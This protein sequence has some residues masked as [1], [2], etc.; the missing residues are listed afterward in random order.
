MTDSN[1][2]NE[3]TEYTRISIRLGEF[4]VEIEGTH[5]NVQSLMGESLYEFIR[6]LQKISEEIPEQVI[7]EEVAPLTEY[8]PPL[9]KPATLKDALKTLMVDTGWGNTPRKLSEIMT[10][11]ETNSLYYSAPSVSKTLVRLMREGTLRRLGSKGSFQ[12]VAA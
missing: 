9:G 12:Y 1:N 11:L 7:S 8:P 5:N 6:G 10:A 3:E 2:E 4:Q